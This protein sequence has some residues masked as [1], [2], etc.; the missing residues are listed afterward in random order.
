MSI[1]KFNVE[2]KENWQGKLLLKPVFPTDDLES[3][4]KTLGDTLMLGGEAK[5]LLVSLGEKAGTK[6]FRK[7]GEAAAKWLK[8]QKVSEAGLDAADFDVE[9]PNALDIFCEGLLLGSFSFDRLK[10]GASGVENISISVLVEGDTAELSNRI[11]RI[12][13]L[14][15]GVNYAR[16]MSHEPAN[17][18][19]PQTLAEKATALAEETGLKCTV[20]GV[21]E[22]AEMG[23]E[24]ILS[25]GLGSKTGSRMIMLEHGGRGEYADA[26]P[27]VV[28]GKAI[29]FD[30]GGYS[31][32]DTK[33]IVDMKFDKSGGM[34][35]MGLMKTLAELDF[36][37]PVIGIVAAAENMIS[38]EAYRP[39]DIIGSLSGKTIEIISTDAEGRM[40]LADALTYASTKLNPRA[41]ID[42]ATLTGGVLVALGMARAGLLSNNDALADALFAAG[43][44]TDELLWRMP[45]DDEYFVLIKGN[46]SDLKNSP[47]LPYASTIVGGMFLK[48]FVM[49]DVPWAHLDI[50]GTASVKKTIL[51]PRIS[52]GFGVRLLMN[53]LENLL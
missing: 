5:T 49:N 48:E 37:Y 36:P 38:A 17:V 40:V 35:V 21:D 6:S 47:G 3:P 33:G 12:G 43:T 46:D 16:A 50:A 53:Y 11:A 20:F 51:G 1:L 14:I 13:S 28:V 23:A 15:A 22:L 2:K 30:T 27:V 24:S 7:A 19:N 34:V 39:N 18:I 42:L 10:S 52:T 8:K 41:I 26:A 32:K 9:T 25:V 4:G 44:R 31:L 29:T 45:L